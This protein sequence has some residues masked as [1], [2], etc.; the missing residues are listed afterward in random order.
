[1]NNITLHQR[2]M[3]FS[4]MEYIIEDDG[5]RII[6]K[7]LA[8]GSDQKLEFEE[9]GS[10]ITTAKSSVLTWMYISI[11]FLIFGVVLVFFENNIGSASFLASVLFFGFFLNSRK[12]AT[13]L[14]QAD[15]TT[16][17]EFV[18][19]S[20]EE[21][22]LKTFLET[23]LEKRNAFLKEKYMKL[24][25]LMPFNQQYSNLIWLY[26]LHLISREELEKKIVELESMGIPMEGI[27]RPGDRI[28]ITGFTKRNDED[29][30]K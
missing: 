16:F 27:E 21:D 20:K 29:G 3:G 19:L 9:I 13:I 11:V 2:S 17:I 30:K 1:M 23:L 10:K 14:S 5:L 12:H 22:S 26:E 28:H 4:R 24:D 8:S 25:S 7:G 15:H 18:H 6:R